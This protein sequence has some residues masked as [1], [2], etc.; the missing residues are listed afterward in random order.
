MRHTFPSLSLPGAA[1]LLAL[2]LAVA[3]PDPALAGQCIY[4]GGD[5]DDGPC[6]EFKNHRDGT[7]DLYC[8][9]GP[10][11]DSHKIAL[12]N[13]SAFRKAVSRRV[14]SGVWG[15]IRYR[16][17]ANIGPPRPLRQAV[18]GDSRPP[19]TRRAGFRPPPSRRSG[20]R[21]TGLTG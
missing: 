19:G 18:S 14:R 21:G 12:A 9:Q 8:L 20:P 2:L 3:A 15:I 11:E 5:T 10:T 17:V 13:G 6:M 1:G 4:T 16:W 7:L